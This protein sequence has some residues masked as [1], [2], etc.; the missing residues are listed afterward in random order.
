MTIPEE[1][2]KKVK[3]VEGDTVEIEARGSG[4]VVLK[5]VIPLPELKEAWADDPSIGKA[6]Q[7]VDKLWKTPEKP[8][9]AEIAGTPV[10]SKA[11]WKETKKALAKAEGMTNEKL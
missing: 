7:E 2:R 8:K 11:D 5:R 4:E 3:L 6:M 10:L 9:L 1:V